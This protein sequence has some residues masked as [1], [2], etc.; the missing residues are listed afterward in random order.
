MFDETEECLFK[1][2]AK[3]LLNWVTLDAENDRVAE[4][5]EN[6]KKIVYVSF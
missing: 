3:W 4:L 6:S 5:A 1:K 2:V